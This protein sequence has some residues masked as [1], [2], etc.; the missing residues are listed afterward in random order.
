M[1]RSEQARPRGVARARYPLPWWRKAYVCCGQPTLV[2]SLM[3]ALVGAGFVV[4]GFALDP[5]LTLVGSILVAVSGL[6]L[7]TFWLL[8]YRAFG[9]Q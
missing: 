5:N 6:M 2:Y 1:N 9:R 4:G 8:A 7:T 3:F